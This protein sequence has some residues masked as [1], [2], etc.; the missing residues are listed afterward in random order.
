MPDKTVQKKNAVK[1]RS[2]VEITTIIR[3]RQSP[4][5]LSIRSIETV[6][7]RYLPIHDDRLLPFFANVS[8]RAPRVLVFNARVIVFS[9][10]ARRQLHHSAMLSIIESI[11]WIETHFN[12]LTRRKKLLVVL[13][14][15]LP[16]FRFFFCVERSVHEYQPKQKENENKSNNDE[17]Q[18]G[19]KLY[20][21]EAFQTIRFPFGSWISISVFLFEVSSNLATYRHP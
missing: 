18:N 14:K 9:L 12:Q 11:T 19:I 7:S 5:S 4:H 10:P 17:K 6:L 3:R 8:A 1:S 16:K 15:C 20:H 13:P 21:G 2:S